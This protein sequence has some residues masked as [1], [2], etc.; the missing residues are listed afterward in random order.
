MDRIQLAYVVCRPG[1]ERGGI[2]ASQVLDTLQRPELLGQDV[3]DHV[4]E[5]KR[6]CILGMGQPD[7]A[8]LPGPG[9][10]VLEQVP[11]RHLDPVR[12]HRKWKCVEAALPGGGILGQAQQAWVLQAKA[13]L[14]GPD[15][16]IDVGVIKRP[17]CHAKPA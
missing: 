1:R 15:T 9:E 4:R 12:S 6:R 16:W 2:K 5:G 11:V 14:E 8:D 17:T 7:R 13:V 3:L 10:H